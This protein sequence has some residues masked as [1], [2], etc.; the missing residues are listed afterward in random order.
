MSLPGMNSMYN[1]PLWT[2]FCCGIECDQRIDQTKRKLE[3]GIEKT[4]IE[5]TVQRRVDLIDHCAKD[6]SS[7][8]DALLLEVFPELDP[9]WLK[10]SH[11][12]NLQIMPEKSSRVTSVA[13]TQLRSTD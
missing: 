6:W 10:Q 13:G 12:L 9:E 2:I 5:I 11:E 8:V 7:C 1:L 3:K 4:H